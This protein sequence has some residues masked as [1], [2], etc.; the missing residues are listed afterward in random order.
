[1]KDD[2]IYKDRRYRINELR[3]KN[4]TLTSHERTRKAINIEEPDRVPVDCWMVSEIKTRCMD[5]WGLESEK[6]LLEF[7][8]ADIRNNYGP[9]FAGQEF[10]TYDDDTVEDLWG[11]KRKIAYA[12]IVSI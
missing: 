6:E 1:V 7:L 4:D 10:K 11:V 9:S 5:Y 2:T 12:T 3:A 8:G